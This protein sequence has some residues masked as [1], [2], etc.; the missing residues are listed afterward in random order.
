MTW[1]IAAAV[2]WTLLI[3]ILCTLPGQNLPGTSIV[4]ADK[5]VHFGMFVGFAVFWL[6]VTR[7]G[8]TS[9]VRNVL[10][11]GL[12][13]AGGTEIY[14]GLLPFHRTPDLYDAL[15]NS[16]GL[17]GGMAGYFFF[18]RRSAHNPASRRNEP[19]FENGDSTSS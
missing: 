16:A 12:L 19:P 6:H 13:F 10:I 17:L 18:W 5:L 4:G 2:G 14:Q 11:A 3:L 15:A 1:K 7:D 8:S 9:A